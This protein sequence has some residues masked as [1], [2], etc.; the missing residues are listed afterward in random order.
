[1][2]RKKNMK[3]SIGNWPDGLI[4]VVLIKYFHQ[5]VDQGQK[6]NS[7]PRE[8]AMNKAISTNQSIENNKCWLIENKQGILK[9][10][11]KF[12]EGFEFNEGHKVQLNDFTQNP[13]L[14][15]IKTF[16]K[17]ESYATKI[18]STTSKN[19][20]N[21]STIIPLLVSII[22]IIIQFMLNIL[23]S[24]TQSFITTTFFHDN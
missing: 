12:L 20:V 19:I 24:S 5:F 14:N 16:C 22:I 21:L 10:L 18:P 4:G 7:L 23:L 8:S 17:I 11:K 15:F 9:A 1:M 3:I 2:I 6:G 13:K